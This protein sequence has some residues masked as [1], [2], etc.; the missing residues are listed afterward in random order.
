M[1]YTFWE[2]RMPAYIRM[3]MRTWEFPHVVLNFDNLHNYT[4]LPMNKLKKF[5]IMQIS[6]VVR[7]HVLRDHGGY[8]LDADTIM[9]STKLPDTM[10]VGDNERRASSI[11]FLKAEAHHPMYEEWADYQDEMLN[12]EPTRYWALMGNAFCDPYLKA[13]PEIKIGNIFEHWLETDDVHDRQRKYVDYYF[14]NTHEPKIP[15]MVM[16]HNSWTP[17]WYKQLTASE[18]LAQDCTLSW[19]LREIRGHH[20]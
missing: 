15:S 12:G 16:L 8:W 18:V 19:I 6:D 4:D 5:T 3:C 20:A 11:G 13:H 2:G 1:I 10:F 9:N 17:H 7:V 14:I